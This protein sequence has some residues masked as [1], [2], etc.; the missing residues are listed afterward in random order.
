MQS[1]NQSKLSNFIGDTKF[2]LKNKIGR[3]KDA[4]AKYT[5]VSACYNV[6]Q[7]LDDFFRSMVR[8]SIGFSKNLFLIMVD[9]GS[10]DDT[11]QI[12]NK[13]ARLY[14]KNICYLHKENGGQASARN[15]G[16]KFVKTPWVTFTDPDDFLND[17]YFENIDIFLRTHKDGKNVSLISTNIIFYYEKDNIFKDNHPLSY[18]FKCEQN[19]FPLNKTG[20]NV[21][22]SAASAVFK[23]SVIQKNKLQFPDLKPNFEDGYFLGDFFI[24]S[25]E[26][27]DNYVACLKN[28]KYFYRK[29]G[30]GN[31]TLDT[32]WKNIKIFSE[33]FTRGFI[34]LLTSASKVSNAS[35]V[36][37]YAVLYALAW[38]VLYILN[39]SE[40]VNFL[41]DEQKKQYLDNL[42]ICFSY[43]TV[44]TIFN[45]TG[46]QMW[47]YHK[48]GMCNCFK[49][50]VPNISPLLYIEKYDAFKDEIQIRYFSCTDD[51]LEHFKI[52]TQ[53]VVPTHVKWIRDDFLGRIFI[54]QRMIWLPLCGIKNKKLSCSINNEQARIACKGQQS[55]EFD[56][57]ELRNIFL[58]NVE[59]LDSGPWLFMDRMTQADDNAEHLYRY[60]KN[61]YSQQEAYYLLNKDSKDWNRLSQDGFKLVEFGSEQ[62]KELSKRC[63]KII[64]SHIDQFV[65][66]FWKDNSLDSKQIVFLQHGITKDD[67]SSWLN[68][69]KRID[70]FVTATVPEYN[71]IVGDYTKYR[72]TD[73]EV[74]LVGFARHDALLNNAE[75][76]KKKVIMIMPTWR[77]SLS[78]NRFG[79]LSLA[80]DFCESKYFISWKSLLHS[81]KL[82][83]LCD[84]F[85]YHVLFV[86]HPNISLA[87]DLFDIPSYIEINKN[88]NQSI[89]DMFKSCAMMITD[90]SSVAFEIGY[91][92]KPVLYYQFDED[93]FWSQQSYQKGYYDYRK[94]GFGSVCVEQNE[95]LEELEKVLSVNCENIPGLQQ[96]VDSTFS[97]RDGRNC[98][99]TLEAILDLD[100]PNESN[101]N[102]KIALDYVN[103][104]IEYNNYEMANDILLQLKEAYPEFSQYDSLLSVVKANN[105][106]ESG[107]L[108]T[109]GSILE[110]LG[111]IEDRFSHARNN[112]FARF[113][114]YTKQWEKARDLLES[115]DLRNDEISMLAIVYKKLGITEM[116]LPAKYN[117]NSDVIKIYEYYINNQNEAL[118]NLVKPIDSS[119][120]ELVAMSVDS[121]NRYYELMK[122]DVFLLSMVS[123]VATLTGEWKVEGKARTYIEKKVGR[124]NLWHI[125]AAD[126]AFNDGRD[127]YFNDVYS[128][129]EQAYSEG[130]SYMSSEEFSMYMDAMSKKFGKKIFI[131]KITIILHEIIM[132][133]TDVN[134]Q[135]S[136]M[137]IVERYKKETVI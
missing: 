75:S 68:T 49:H 59:H 42:D 81:E 92:G 62:H 98:Q 99:R 77:T 88:T 27:S 80:D 76:M 66:N 101:L 107:K 85:G 44:D 73:K 24:H 69:K 126:R 70:L 45:F 48:M 96:L 10:T 28:S 52:G 33:L 74:K 20:K 23:M 47:H 36:V 130:I 102:E 122:D 54:Y 53:T 21:Q 71:S 56:L 43:I 86:P 106:I 57:N 84:K 82:K 129:L 17:E 78:T 121:V 65:V 3:T 7:Y 31:S 131:E 22:L 6:S 34:P 103:K 38:H 112:I 12:I 39:R 37:Q 40:R 94:D 113:Y 41:T 135:Q 26:N 137:D 118:I 30:D 109:A 72:F 64:S 132:P 117:V 60:I 87:M 55:K 2:Y 116:E 13:W 119:S 93:T 124:N 90:Y 114:F 51:S 18:K 16:L 125:L 123:E 8:Q 91:L 67:L 15:L 5:V 9:D 14:P 58:A 29:R 35:K 104:A 11:A 108:L 136:F 32:A 25:G 79:K 111:V 63:T 89:Q 127:K 95:L 83:S 61:N 105:A 133:M 128:N 110:N 50:I 4:Y 97:T 1:I 100:K 115:Y 19:V 46:C 120:A 134:K